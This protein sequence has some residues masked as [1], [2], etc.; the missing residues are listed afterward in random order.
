MFIAVAVAFKGLVA[1]RGLT[2]NVFK[3]AFKA[4]RVFKGVTAELCQLDI[5]VALL[6][7][8]EL[9]PTRPLPPEVRTRLLAGRT[10]V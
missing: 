10:S 1:F 4:F 9:L 3:A 7:P 8:P 5:L 2:F 6:L